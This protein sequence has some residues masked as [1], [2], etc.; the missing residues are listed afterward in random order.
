VRGIDW[1][2]VRWELQ[3]I[4]AMALRHVGVNREYQHALDKR[5]VISRAP[6]R[7]PDVVEVLRVTHPRARG[8]P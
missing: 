8:L 2:H 1:G 6:R 5:G 3:E 7:P 4:S